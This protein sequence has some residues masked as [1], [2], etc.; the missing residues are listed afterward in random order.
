M[1]TFILL[2]ALPGSGKSTWAEEYRLTHKNVFIVSSDSLRKE[3]TGGLGFSDKEGIVW[4]RFRSDI[5]KYRDY[6]DDVTVIADATNI[7]NGH[8][9]SFAEG[10]VG[11]DKYVLVI[12]KKPHDEVLKGNKLRSEEKFVPEEAIS[13]MESRWQDVND[14][15]KDFYD[16][17]IEIDKHFEA[18]HVKDEFHY[19]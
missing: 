8:R 15:V 1:K 3:I 10:A 12:F 7:T 16:E 9:L 6:S 18:P 11:F 14:E 2:S 17:I 5:L 19:D 13:G 4:D